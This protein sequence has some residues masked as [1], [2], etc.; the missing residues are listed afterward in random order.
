MPHLT[1]FWLQQ[2]SVEEKAMIDKAC[3]ILRDWNG[4]FL[5]V[6]IQNDIYTMLIESRDCTE[7]RPQDIWKK[8][9]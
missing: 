3:G 8:L 9:V 2:L 6:F 7:Q 4:F 5:Y 1:Y